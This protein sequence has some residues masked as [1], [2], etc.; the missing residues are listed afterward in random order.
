MEYGIKI[1]EEAISD[2]SALTAEAYNDLLKFADLY[3]KDAG[4]FVENY[5][6][7]ID[8]LGNSITN[9][10]Y[11]CLELLQDRQIHMIHSDDDILFSTEMLLAA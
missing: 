2:F 1:L 8:M 11:S 6:Q 10:D 3:L 9:F 5:T 4:L 7:Q